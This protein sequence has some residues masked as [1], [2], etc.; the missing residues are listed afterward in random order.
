[1]Q[2]SEVTY[3]KIVA[4]SEHPDV[5]SAAEELVE[6]FFADKSR[7]KDVEDYLRTAKKLI[8]SLWYRG[9]NTD[10]FRF[11]TKDLYFSESGRTHPKKTKAHKTTRNQKTTTTS[12][13]KADR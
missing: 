2:L 6:S 7:R 10:L 4:Y 1:M 11:T 9:P 8:A 5:T 3:L 13:P 12:T